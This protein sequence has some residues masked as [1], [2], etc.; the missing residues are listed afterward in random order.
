MTPDFG[1]YAPLPAHKAEPGWDGVKTDRLAADP[2][3]QAAD[4]A[5]VNAWVN[6]Q[7]TYVLDPANWRTPSQTLAK[8]TGDCKDYAVL[9]RA[10]LLAKGFAEDELFLVVGQ[11]LVMNELHAV[12]WTADGVM[13]DMKDDL[14][15]P[16]DLQSVFTPEFAFREGQSFVYGVRPQPP[17]PPSNPA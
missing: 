12:M 4:A 1:R 8:L 15:S 10:I 11:D 6:Q 14:L 13:D 5:A 16:D 2:C 3:P 9:K 17:A 7:V